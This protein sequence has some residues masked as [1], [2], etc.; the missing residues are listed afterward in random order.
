MVS[1]KRIYTDPINQI[2]VWLLSK[3]IAMQI[4]RSTKYVW[5]FGILLKKKRVQNKKNMKSTC[6]K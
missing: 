1:P 5:V 4:Q 2:V 6:S 3:V